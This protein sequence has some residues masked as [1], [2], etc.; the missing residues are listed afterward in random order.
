MLILSTY[1][2][3]DCFCGWNQNELGVPWSTP[4]NSD[5]EHEEDNHPLIEDNVRSQSPYL[6]TL[7]LL[8]KKRWKLLLSVL[9]ALIIGASILI[10]YLY[11]KGI[12]SVFSYQGVWLLNGYKYAM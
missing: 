2:R 5:E 9:L 3:Q 11:N 6:I 12:N 10:G 8:C 7:L 4:D 1:E